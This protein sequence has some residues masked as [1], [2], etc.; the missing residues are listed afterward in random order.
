MAIDFR[1]PHYSWKLPWFI[2]DLFTAQIITTYTVPGD[3]SDTKD[4]VLTETPIPGLNFSPIMPGGNGNRKIAFTLPLM[5]RNNTMGNTLVLK[6]FDNLRNQ[7]RRLEDIFANQFNP[8]PKV[9]FY[10][11]IGSLPLVYYVKK[12]DFSHKE[13][14]TNEMGFPQFTEISL[15]LWLDENNLV[16][17]AEE[18]FR[19]VASMVNLGIESISGAT[20]AIGITKGKAV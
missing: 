2:Y 18:I 7:A 5:K 17:K 6:Q 8:N 15:E 19:K 16:Y 1:L 11:G 12:C 10:W 3:I 13:H 4:I 14:W 9:L 20:T